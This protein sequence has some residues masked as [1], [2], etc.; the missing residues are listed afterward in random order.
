MLL[1][2][3][4]SY[5]DLG[6]PAERVACITFRKSRFMLASSFLVG[7]RFSSSRFCFASTVELLSET[8]N[9]ESHGYA[10][11]RM[12]LEP[13]NSIQQFVH[14]D[15]VRRSYCPEKWFATVRTLLR[16]GIVFSSRNAKPRRTAGA[17]KFESQNVLRFDNYSLVSGHVASEVML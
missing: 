15:I 1:M 4:K 14:L 9:L 17:F 10:L 11:R 13:L 16:Q 8:L 6:L 7:T 3:A 2:E 12:T 5:F